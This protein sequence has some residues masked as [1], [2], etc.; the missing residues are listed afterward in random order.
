MQAEE[1]AELIVR[2]ARSAL[3]GRK[4]PAGDLQDVKVTTVFHYGAVDIDTKHLVVWVLLDGASPD[5]LPTWWSSDSSSRGTSDEECDSW[6][7]SIT[8]T[9][10]QRF[11]EA[12]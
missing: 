6:L 7:R 3:V 12:R 2:D 4:C 10:R 11:E 1:V 8:S 5:D 9:I